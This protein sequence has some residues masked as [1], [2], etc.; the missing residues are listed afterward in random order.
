MQDLNDG[1]TGVPPVVSHVR[2]TEDVLAPYREPS[3]PSAAKSSS[4]QIQRR[5]DGKSF[6]H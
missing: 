3:M 4:L 2:T 1:A 5:Y 6:L